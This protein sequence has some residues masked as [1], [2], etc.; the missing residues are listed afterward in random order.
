MS[1][2]FRA[3]IVLSLLSPIDAL[4]EAPTASSMSTEGAAVSTSAA[5]T[6][7]RGSYQWVPPEYMVD[8]NSGPV[9]AAGAPMIIYMN[10]EGG[11]Y[12][13][14]YNNSS[15]NSSTIVR[16]TSVISPW[17]VSDEAWEQVMSC[18]T[19]QFSPFNVIVT[20]EDPGAV[21]HVESVVAGYPQDIGMQG[22]AGVSPFTCSVLDRSI[23]FTFAELFGGNYRMVCEV[24]AQEVAHSF[25]LDHEYLC[26]DPMTYL[27]G[28]GLKEFQD[29]DAPCGEYSQ[30]QCSCGGSTQNS[31][32]VMLDRLGPADPVP[33]TLVVDHPVAGEEVDA[34]F[35]V[36]ATASDDKT[37]PTVE[38]FID[39]QLEETLV[40]APY[41]AATRADL[42]SGVHFLTVRASD[43]RNKTE[44]TVQVLV[45][46][47]DM[48]E[49]CNKNE[50][51][52][53]GFDCGGGA[54]TAESTSYDDGGLGAW[55]FQDEQCDSEMCA[56]ASDAGRCVAFCDSETEGTCPEGF[57]CIPASNDSSICWPEPDSSG[58][59]S[60]CSATSGRHAPVSG[61]VV[62]ALAALGL[63]RRRQRGHVSSS[64]L[65]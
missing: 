22:A 46:G 2:C 16:G 8:P 35:E 23:V 41:A 19:Y 64:N 63:R 18:V 57:G 44:H 42:P 9:A 47:S 7:L 11:T 65:R 53:S 32:K 31:V 29:V 54:C 62:L 49:S 40:A 13:P 51:C 6:P 28:C 37:D 45:R 12:T 52:P 1:R 60:G 15:T 10:R 27:S 61:L 30:R 58:D 56:F 4:A 17:Q 55:C 50:D 3:A 5:A 21:A 34:G 20:D 39:G 25:G 43:G 59:S 48:P 36:Q 38:V 24:V 14:G 26:S 33:P